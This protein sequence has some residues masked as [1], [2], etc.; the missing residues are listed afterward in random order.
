MRHQNIYYPETRFG[1]FTDIDGTISFYTRVNELLSAKSI[2]VDVGCG[3]G[4]CTDDPITT[5]RNL[6]IMKG[7]CKKVIGI[8][9]DP[10]GENNPY[11]DQFCLIENDCWQVEDSTVDL[12]ICDSVLEH[13]PDVEKFFSECRRVLKPGGYFCA[14]TPNLCSF[15]G[16]ASKLIP[17][18]FHKSVI[19]FVQ[20]NRKNED[21][22]PTLYRCNT[23]RKFRKILAVNGFEFC[24]YGY[25]AEPSYANFSRVFYYLTAFSHRF[26]PNNF[27]STLFAF[28]KKI[29]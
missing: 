15:F 20:K 12:C 13:V 2:V 22:F 24:V 29:H 5:R 26:I 14:R 1:G 6:R 9:V 11:L 19:R 3:R 17:N 8:D 16:L 18:K 25:E 10:A 7:K 27:K 23:K 21:V 28:A 4:K